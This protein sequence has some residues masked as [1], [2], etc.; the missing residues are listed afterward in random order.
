MRLLCRFVVNYYSSDFL[1]GRVAGASRE[2]NR[3]RKLVPRTKFSS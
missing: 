3:R 1:N 2:V